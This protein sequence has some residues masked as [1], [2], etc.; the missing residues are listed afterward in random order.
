MAILFTI[1]FSYKSRNSNNNDHKSK[2]DSDRK[3]LNRCFFSPLSHVSSYLVFATS[4]YGVG[5]VENG[6]VLAFPPEPQSLSFGD[7]FKTIVL[8]Q[9]GQ[10]AVSDIWS[11]CFP[12]YMAS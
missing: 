7:L 5:I 10:N 6:L 9:M 2:K 12:F 8:T 11:M 4:V 3:N 1:F